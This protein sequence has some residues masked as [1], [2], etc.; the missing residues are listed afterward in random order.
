MRS[1]ETL[2]SDT[3]FVPPALLHLP[4]WSEQTW[5]SVPLWASLG[6]PSNIDRG[7]HT[8]RKETALGKG[9]SAMLPRPSALDLALARPKAGASDPW[10]S[11][12][13]KRG[14]V[15]EGCATC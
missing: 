15:R 1:R 10:L 13:D 6:E 3:D 12:W 7:R 4:L 5:G 14:C 11:V 9:C 8:W 2:F